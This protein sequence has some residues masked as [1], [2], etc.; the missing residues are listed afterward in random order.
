MLY[1]AFRRSL[2]IESILGIAVLIVASFLSINSPPSL[3][4]LGGE[5]INIQANNVNNYDNSFF[6][7]LV[8]SL[9]IIISVIGIVNY[10]KNQKQ[11]KIISTITGNGS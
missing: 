2:K 8:I 5:S 3:E 7:Y 6:F 10:K 4:V 11:I 1:K 9:V